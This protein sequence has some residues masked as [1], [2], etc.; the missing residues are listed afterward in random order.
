MAKIL[1]VLTR[2]ND[3]LAREIVSRQ[4]QEP[5]QQVETVDLTQE[6]RDYPAL[7]KRIFEADS[8]A[9]W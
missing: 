7:L 2:E 9:V 3:D 4:R 6:Q 5:T 1:H 8:V